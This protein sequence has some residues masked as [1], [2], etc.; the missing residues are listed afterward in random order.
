[1]R[2]NILI[3]V[4]PLIITI[5][6]N[7]Y[8]DIVSCKTE[9]SFW[10]DT[11]HIVDSLSSLYQNESCFFI[12]TNYLNT[13][14]ITIYPYISYFKERYKRDNRDPSLLYAANEKNKISWY[15]I[16]SLKTNKTLHKEI[17]IE[18]KQDSLHMIPD[19]FSYRIIIRTDSNYMSTFLLAERISFFNSFTCTSSIIFSDTLILRRRIFFIKSD[20]QIRKSSNASGMQLFTELYNFSNSEGRYIKIKDY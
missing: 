12:D 9:R 18:K 3:C 8:P 20:M 11:K 4:S 14:T 17:I 16:D 15:L 10:K 7:D 1:M 6:C 5:S 19:F 2:R 13:Y